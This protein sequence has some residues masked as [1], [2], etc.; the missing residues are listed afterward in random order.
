MRKVTL[1]IFVVLTS[2]V[3]MQ[4]DSTRRAMAQSCGDPPPPP[5]VTPEIC[6]NQNLYWDGCYCTGNSPIIIDLSGNGYKLTSAANGVWFDLPGNGR[7]QQWSWTSRDSDEAFLMLDRNGDGRITSGKE[8]FG[9][10]TE[11]PVTEEPNG[12]TA[13]TVFDENGDHWIDASD[14]IYQRLQLWIDSNHD[15]VSQRREL[16]SLNEKGV[17]GISCDYRL[18]KRSDRYGNRFRFKARARVNGIER[19]VWDIFLVSL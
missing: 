1:L 19:W 10:V 6:A 18:S 14:P 3:I 5:C 12:F 8:L 15:G 17:E 9:D 13:L 2:L 7:L 11:Q 4:S 16:F